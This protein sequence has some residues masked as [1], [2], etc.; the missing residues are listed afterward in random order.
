MTDD[1]Q[2]KPAPP[3]FD[4]NEWRGKPAP[5]VD[6]TKVGRKKRMKKLADSAPKTDRRSLKATGRTEPLFVRMN[7]T[8]KKAMEQHAG[9]G[10]VSLWL[11]QAVLAQ[12]EAEGYDLD[13]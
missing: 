7:P 6:P 4:M 5:K 10:N 12:L 8:V 3:I 11:E 13:G 2:Q 9:K 1:V